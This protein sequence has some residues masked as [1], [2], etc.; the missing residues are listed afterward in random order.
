MLEGPAE[1]VTTRILPDS[2]DAE[3]VTVATPAL[4]ADFAKKT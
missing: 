1:N 4:Q 3:P 2:R